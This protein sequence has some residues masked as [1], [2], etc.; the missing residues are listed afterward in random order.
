MQNV[1]TKVARENTFDLLLRIRN[2]HGNDHRIVK[3]FFVGVS[4]HFKSIHLNA[5]TRL[6]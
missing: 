6:K 4:K 2:K 1:E 3:Y 5:Y